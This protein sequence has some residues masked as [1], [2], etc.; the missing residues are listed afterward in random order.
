VGEFAIKWGEMMAA[1]V[2]TSIPV[3]FIFIFLS[4]QLIGGLT[5]GA[6]KG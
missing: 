4:K 2:V 6:V 1:S 3:I 5:A